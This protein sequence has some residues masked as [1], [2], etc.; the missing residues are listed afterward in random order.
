MYTIIRTRALEYELYEVWVNDFTEDDTD[1]AREKETKE[2][3]HGGGDAHRS[4]LIH[5]DLINEN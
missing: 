3:V 1:D 2:S 4:F 5:R